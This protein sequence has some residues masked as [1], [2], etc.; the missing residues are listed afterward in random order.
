MSVSASTGI[1]ERDVAT[2]ATVDAL[3]RRVAAWRDARESVALVPTMGALH[4]GHLALVARARAL[5][6]R[7]GPGLLGRMLEGEFRP[8]HFV[9][10]ATVVAK[11]LLQ[12]APDVAVFGEKDY[13]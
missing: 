13:Q 6:R 9:G 5:A 1:G 3:R 4:A 11:L 2:V 10:G 7:V 8:G 12:T